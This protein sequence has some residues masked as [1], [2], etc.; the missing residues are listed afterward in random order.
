MMK[1][2]Y[3]F[4]LLFGL[5]P[6]AL[7]DGLPELGD[8]SATVMS[9]LDEQRIADEIMRDVYASSQVLEDPEVNDY[10][11]ALGYRLAANGPDKYQRFNFF[12]V[13]DS[14]INAFAMPGGVIGVHTGLLLAAKNESE[15]AGVLGHEIGHV[16][17]RHLARM[18][19][20]QK[21]D[22]VISMATMALALLAA[23][24]N[25]Q[26]TG[27]ALTAATAGSIQKRIDYTR[28]HEREADRVG[29][30]IMAD[31]GFDTRAMPSFFETL[32]KGTRFS[33]GSAP[34]F[35]RTHP[36]TVER[37]ADVRNR[38]EQGSFR[39]VQENP[40]FYFIKAKLLANIGTADSAINIFR[41]NLQEK[42]YVNEAA[43][44]YGI[45]LAMLRKN[46]LAGAHKEVAW[47]RQHTASNALIETLAT[48]VAVAG[49]P[50]AVAEQRY[51]D[52]LGLYPGHRALI[53]G[54]AEHLLGSRQSEKLLQL[55]ADKQAQ[56]PD[57]PYFY[58]LKARAYSMQGKSLLMHQAQ[59]EA[60]VRR[61]NLRGA[62]EQMDLAAKAAD[63]D[64]YEKSIVEARLNQL[65]RQ[66]DDKRSS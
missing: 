48:K 22:S 2:L 45:A 41:I 26:L 42:H 5:T 6:M 15:V 31:A 3:P 63:G 32:Q 50:P 47:L 4:A 56:F 57:D 20:K 39:V 61:Y 12:V 54:Y 10:I 59:G 64:F 46:D 60:Y 9:P 55:I 25:P 44:H 49:Q 21:N 34:A 33:E 35:L 18:L 23:R 19:A 14:S 16:V 62:V 24:S 27:G 58:E 28:E 8:Y 65:R 13:K 52:A 51:L 40:D 37:I 53:Y 17:Q 36:L 11:T 29:L 7:A 43:E 30:Q 1:A 38:V 66:L